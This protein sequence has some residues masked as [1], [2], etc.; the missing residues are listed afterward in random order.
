MKRV[1][2]VA[3]LAM[4]VFACGGGG[5]LPSSQPSAAQPSGGAS[6]PPAPADAVELTFWTFV[7]RHATFF[8]SRAAAWNEENPDRPVTINPSVVEYNQMHDNL[9]AALLAGTGAPDIVDIEIGKF[10]NYVKGDLHLL[11]MTA[12]IEPYVADLVETRLAPYEFDG[13]RLAADY[14][15]GAFLA[16]YNK[17]IMDAAGVNVDDIKTWD[18][19]IEAGKQVTKEGV[20]MAAIDVNG[21]MSVRG[22]MLQN[23]GGVYDA[24]GTLIIDS[25]E[26]VEALQLVADMVV[27]HKIAAASPGGNNG[28]PEFYQ[29]MADGQF[30]S[31]WMPQWYMTRFPDNMA[32]LEGKMV[33]RPMPLFEEGGFTTTMGGGTG[34]AV[35]DQTPEAEQ[36]LAKDFVTYAKLTKEGQTAIWTDLGFDPYRNDVYDD[37]ALQEPDPYFSNEVTF[38]IIKSELG[39]VAPEYTGPQYPEIQDYLNTTLIYDIV[40]NGVSPAD[41]A[42]AAQAAIEAAQ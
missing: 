30:A 18:D 13:K 22:L 17:E 24:D 14:H 10:A 19:Y 21:P 5:T 42:A 36:Q 26:N 12:E 39:N 9:T 8:E 15:L 20:T 28:T 1:L 37:P 40:Q 7:D 6:L 33:V 3:A 35:T 38:E 34:T 23:G 27:T 31:L 41:A 11:D 16:F 25:P 29:A 2:V 32:G 4:T